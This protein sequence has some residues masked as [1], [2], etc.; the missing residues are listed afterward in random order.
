MVKP[1]ARLRTHADFGLAIQQARMARGMSQIEL[2]EEL[3]V[4]QSTISEIE[5][6]KSTIYLRRVLALARVTGIEF[7][8][9]WDGLHGCRSL[10]DSISTPFR[11]QV[12]ISQQR[13][14][15]TQVAGYRACQAVG[16]QVRGGERLQ[17][18]HRSPS[19]WWTPNRP[20]GHFPACEAGCRSHLVKGS[21]AFLTGYRLIVTLI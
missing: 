11:N 1:T 13:P 3:G 17:S 4:T 14:D 21:L 5:S 2:A 12:L 19:L 16:R 10:D 6:G 20:C 15:A 7:A 8:A 9:T 18:S